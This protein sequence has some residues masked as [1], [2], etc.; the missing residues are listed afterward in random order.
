M[1]AGKT[2]QAGDEITISYG[3]KCNMEVFALQERGSSFVCVCVCWSAPT[4][5]CATKRWSALTCACGDA[6]CGRR[7][8]ASRA[9][10]RVRR[11]LYMCEQLHVH[12]GFSVAD[13]QRYTLCH[14]SPRSA[15]GVCWCDLDLPQD[16]EL[17]QTIPPCCSRRTRW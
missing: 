2:L 11:V 15:R 1:Y 17:P 13:N 5:L 4:T 7:V 12:Y 14:A 6:V 8:G 9:P 10:A 3:D 16:L